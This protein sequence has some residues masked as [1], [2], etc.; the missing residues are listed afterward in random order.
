MILV[1]GDGS[2]DRW[3]ILARDKRERERETEKNQPLRQHEARPNPLICRS[4]SRSA[5]AIRSTAVEAHWL[6]CVGRTSCN[7]ASTDL[8]LKKELKTA[9]EERKK[10]TKKERKKARKKERKKETEKERKKETK[11]EREKE[12]Q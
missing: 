5:Y 12:R 1:R 6:R 8:F 2:A 4:F 7:R 9:E 11:K 3:A 10:Q